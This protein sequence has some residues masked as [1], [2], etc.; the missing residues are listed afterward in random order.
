MLKLGL[1]IWILVGESI[2]R[3]WLGESSNPS[4]FRGELNADALMFVLG[5]NFNSGVEVMF[6]LKFVFEISAR[7]FA[8][9]ERSSRGR[10]ADF[11]SGEPLPG[12]GSRPTG[13]PS[14]NMSKSAVK[15]WNM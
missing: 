4:P 13:P 15:S 1:V 10:L 12:I 8:D 11:F 3:R 9:R 5:V 6:L 7:I 14:A 2:S